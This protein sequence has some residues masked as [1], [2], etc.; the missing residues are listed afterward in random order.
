[1]AIKTKDVRS[2]KSGTKLAHVADAESNLHGV[3]IWNLRVLIVPDGRF[4]FAQGIEID[5]GVQ[6]DSVEDAKKKFGKG[7]AATIHHHLT[8][9]G[10]IDRLLKVVPNDVWKDLWKSKL[11]A[12]LK[13]DCISIH[14]I[15]PKAKSDLLPFE[16]IQYCEVRESGMAA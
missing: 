4:W 8:I 14:D 9:F 10:G 5:Y 11:K 6:G 15:M 3:G 16:V 2:T 12:N 7:L 1:M 13:Y